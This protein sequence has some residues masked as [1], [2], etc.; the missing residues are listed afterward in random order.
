MTPETR[1]MLKGLRECID[2]TAAAQGDPVL[3][4]ALKESTLAIHFQ[5]MTGAAAEQML[6][7]G[8]THIGVPLIVTACKIA[9]ELCE[10]EGL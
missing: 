8:D 6:A 2:A 7:N 3:A 10:S 9:R 4:D 1:D 5:A